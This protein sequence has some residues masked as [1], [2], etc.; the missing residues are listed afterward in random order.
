LATGG[1]AVTDWK[2]D[3]DALVDK[4]MA[5]AKTARREALATDLAER[6]RLE[7][8]NWGGPQ[9]E[10]IRPRVSNFK[11]HQQR[12][13]KEREDYATSTLKKMNRSPI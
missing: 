3:R 2:T 5:F 13:T 9:R 11:A 10:E 7:P 1:K 4:G 12:L 6:P 8:M